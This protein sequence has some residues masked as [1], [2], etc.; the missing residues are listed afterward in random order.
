MEERD[1]KTLIESILAGEHGIR[2]DFERDLGH[3]P[4]PPASDLAA[5]RRMPVG[6]QPPAQ[7]V[8]LD[9][10]VQLVDYHAPHFSLTDPTG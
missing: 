2:D 10:P 7:E 9:H 4:V 5:N 1:D 6:G 3:L 8:D